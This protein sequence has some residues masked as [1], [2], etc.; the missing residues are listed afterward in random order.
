MDALGPNRMAVIVRD[1]SPGIV[2]LETPVVLYTSVEDFYR[3]LVIE[4]NERR[5]LGAW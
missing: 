5:N 2:L 1:I 4:Q 3:D